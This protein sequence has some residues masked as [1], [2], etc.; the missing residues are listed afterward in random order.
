MYRN[1]RFGDVMKGLERGTFEKIVRDFEA[2]KHSKGF[3]CWDQLIAMVYAQLSGC[4][5][6]R[7]VE[8]GFNS[9][10]AHHYHLG[11]RPIKRSTLADA[12]TKR[13]SEVYERVCQH[14]LQQAH[15][16]VRR[17][18]SELL[19]LIDA[20]PIPL[21]GLGFDEWTRETHSHRTQGLK[22]HMVLAP[23]VGLPVFTEITA[24]NVSDVEVGREVVLEEGATYVF[25][26]G[27]CDYNWW[28]RI[29]CNNSIFVTR[30]K[31]NAGIEQVESRAVPAAQAGVVL[32]DALVTFKHKHPGGGRCN[33]YHG[34]AFRRVVIAREGKSTPLILATNDLERSAKEL[35]DLYKRRWEIELFFKWLKQNLKIKQF[36]GRS[37]NAVKIQLYTAII[38]YLLVSLYRRRHGIKES[39]KLCLVTLRSGLFQRPEIEHRRHRKRRERRLEYE[40][41]QGALLL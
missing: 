19:Y 22:V 5:S 15:R 4:R 34:T 26:K 27:Y 1:T 12:N 13:S 11:S 21:K 32:E 37:E 41:L 25:D 20:S 28:Y 7:E 10:T 2:D 40:R 30:L 16:Q 33:D 39:L 14:L 9:Q 6:L 31:K 38:T 23:D 17:D 18:V 36:L 3:R 29:H 35:G 8:T 24:P